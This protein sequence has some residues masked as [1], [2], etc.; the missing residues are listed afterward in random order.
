MSAHSL[1]KDKYESNKAPRKRG[2]TLTEIAIVL[3]IIGLILGAIWGAAS[4]VYAN[5]KVSDAER[6]ITSTAAAVRSSFATSNSTGAASAGA[7]ITTPGMLPVAWTSSGG[8]YGNPWAPSSGGTF[9]YVLGDSG[10][11]TDFA[12]E[13]DGLTA[14]GCAALLSYFSSAASSLN[15]GQI[16]GL[17]GAKNGTSATIASG[18]ATGASAAVANWTN[19]IP[20]NCTAVTPSTAGTAGNNWVVFWF[21]MANM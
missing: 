10:A 12:V 20:G 18:T 8:A 19:A 4:S 7:K 13:L 5:K 15:G 16:T 1:L 14:Q 3:G 11:L 6:G 21:N 17:I 2:F 9:A